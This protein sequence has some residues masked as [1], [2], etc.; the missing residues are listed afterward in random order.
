MIIVSQGKDELVNFDRI[1]S[2]WIDVE[3]GRVT[4]EATADTNSTL[5][6][7]STEERAKEVL[8]GI[9]NAYEKAGNIAFETSEDERL[10]RLTHNSSV[11]EMPE[12]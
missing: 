6:T 5:G 3:E 1:E 7:Y 4:I 2:I 11:F 12:K 10:M 8:Q 9:I